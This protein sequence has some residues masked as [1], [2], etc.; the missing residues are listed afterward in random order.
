MPYTRR[1]KYDM[2]TALNVA[3]DLLYTLLAANKDSYLISMIVNPFRTRKLRTYV[4][5]SWGWG[6]HIP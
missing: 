3:V 4:V 5:G 6:N 1:E 2:R